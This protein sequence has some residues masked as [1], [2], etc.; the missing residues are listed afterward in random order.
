MNQFED[1]QG[2][3]LVTIEKDSE[4]TELIFILEDGRKCKLYHQQ[5]C[6][7]DVHIAEI[8]GDLDDLI[9]TTIHQAEEI[10]SND[11]LAPESEYGPPMSFTWTFYRMATVKGAVT[12]RW[13][14]E[15]NGYYSESV[16]FATWEEDSWKHHYQDLE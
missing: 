2:E 3:I 13:L 5:G 10:S 7:E 15:S 6:C 4:N 12:I 14:G 11:F 9:G 1:L 16:D 8:V